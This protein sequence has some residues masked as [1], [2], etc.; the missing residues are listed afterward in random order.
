VTSSVTDASHAVGNAVGN[1]VS[2]KKPLNPEMDL[3]SILGL[4][5]WF[6]CV[7]YSSIRSSSNAQAAKLTLTD[8]I[9][10][11]EAE[12]GERG[13]DGQQT[14]P[15]ESEGGGDERDGVN[16]NWSLF[17]VMFA[18]ATLYVMMTLTNWYAPGNEVSIDS[19]HANMSAVWVK[20]TSAWL[21]FILYMWT[22][23]A[24][25]LFPDRDFSV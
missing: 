4:V 20:I 12:E 2:G 17:H 9:T 11:T 5:I 19:I 22:L 13:Q 24:P 1:L 10:L 16:Y 7:L 18:L 3:A 14:E 21:C 6:C 25:T 23:I 8:K 15:S